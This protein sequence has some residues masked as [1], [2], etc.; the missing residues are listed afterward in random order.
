MKEIQIIGAKEHNL[1]NVSLTL[2]RDQFI[3]FTGVS[4]SGKS[5]LAFDTIYA[6]AQR[7]YIESMSRYATQYLKPME[8]AKVESIKGLSPAIAIDQKSASMSPRSTVGTVTEIQD[9]LRVLFARIGLPHCPFCGQTVQ[10]QSTQQIVQRITSWPEKTKLQIL[11]PVV[12]GRK[13]DYN[14]LFQQLQKEGFSRVVVDGQS[15]LLDELPEDYRLARNKTHNIEVVIDRIVLKQ[16]DAA[17]LSRLNQSVKRA[18]KKSDGFVQIEKFSDHGSSELLW[19]ST[20]LACPEHDDIGIEE[21]APRLFS[22]N[23]PYGACK[24]CDGLGVAFE[25]DEEKLIADTS[26]S[27]AEGAI[28]P[29]NRILGRQTRYY[30]KHVCKHFRIPFE[31]SVSQLSDKQKQTLL[32]GKADNLKPE[33]DYDMLPKGSDREGEG[34]QPFWMEM[35]EQFDGVINLLKRRYLFGVEK[36]YLEDFMME[37]VCQTC[38]GQRLKAVS[39]SVTLG[40]KNIAQ[41]S[42]LTIIEAAQ[43]FKKLPLQLSSDQLNI[44]RLALQ[45]IEKRLQF[46]QDVGLGYLTLSRSVATLSGGEA[47]RIRLASQ[48]GSGLSGVLYVLDEPSIGLHPE[49]NQQLIQTLK[50]LRDLG[51]TVLVVEHDEATIKAADWLVDIGP[52]AGRLGGQVLS[53]GTITEIQKH[54]ES[55]TASYLR[56]ESKL[57]PPKNYRKQEQGFIEVKGA[58][59]HNLKNIDVQF[60][61]GNLVAITGMSG[62]GKSTLV[63]NLLFDILRQQFGKH[64]A[65]ATGYKKITGLEL[66]DKFIEIDQSPIGRSPRSNPATYTGVFDPMR[67]LFAAS[68][69][70]KIAGLTPSH[71]SFNTAQGRCGHCKGDGWLKQS[72]NFLPDVYAICEVCQGKRYNAETLACRL[73]GKSIADTLDMPISDALE[74]FDDFDSV[75]RLLQVLVDTGL[76]YISLGQSATTLS[77]GEAQRLKLA[78]EFCKKATGKTLYILDEPTIGLHWQDLE[79]LLLILNKLVDDG[80]TVIVIEHDLDFIKMCDWVIDLGP[81]GGPDGGEV[82]ATGS[83][84][85]VSQNPKSLTGQHLKRVLG[86]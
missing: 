76:G 27:L 22:F 45:E 36:D 29:L 21:M 66:I 46:L 4:G 39:L 49:N 83:P 12:R 53:S 31:K 13:G 56:L 3:V 10:S 59:L 8:K 6:E 24:A 86:H 57:L 68:K 20:H 61:L 75:K 23:S 43:F 65:K 79:K 37:S 62:S 85:T 35:A 54:S 7:A 51:N 70:A 42:E 5:S 73:R 19:F 30:L 11:S 71:F 77:G 72:M 16:S 84:K 34:E 28:I 67:K 82:I 55:P 1:K 52:G 15:Q 2:P 81:L 74:F 18:I 60:P 50:N 33:I 64:R 41:L 25:I 63:F 32:Y 58:T 40:E 80:N 14:A 78:T 47:Q 69:E 26:L 38:Q 9:Y 44:G 17:L 48:I